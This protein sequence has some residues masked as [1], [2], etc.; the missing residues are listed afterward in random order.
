MVN[1]SG[2]G[3]WS[4]P[5][6]DGICTLNLDV[7]AKSTV[8]GKRRRR[9]FSQ[10]TAALELWPKERKAL[11]KQWLKSTATNR[12]WRDLLR[13]AGN[14]RFAE[15]GALLLALLETGWVEVQ[16]ERKQGQ[17]QTARVEFIALESL[18]ELV[19][20]KNRQQLAQQQRQLNELHFSHPMLEL[21]RQDLNDMPAER[22]L[23][24]YELLSALE[25]W[26]EQQQYGTRRDF[27]QFARGATKSVSSSEWSW[28]SEGLDLD[29]WGVGKHT[30]VLMFGANCQLLFDSGQLDLAAVPDFIALSPETVAAVKSITNPPRH[31]RIV[32]NQ[33][34]FEK[35]S[36]QID[37]DEALLMVPGHPPRW[38]QT[39]V[40]RLFELAPA[41]IAVACD[42]DPAGIWIAQTI[43]R[44]CERCD[45]NWFPWYMG[46]D[47]LLRLKHKLPLSERDRVLLKTLGDSS[48]PES[49]HALIRTMEREGI[50]GEQEELFRNL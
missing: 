50:K 28:L 31:W 32:E 25:S 37:R 48:L 42:P 11:L 20:L 22:A 7:G 43:G 24:R 34:C 39:A 38:W 1:D 47:D 21:L 46:S 9:C 8:R 5:D 26:R 27:S 10:S 13:L 17:W 30:A 6:S 2:Q 16:E 4:E 15:A 33:T 23:K 40:S 12:L 35:L 18:R 49:L 29:E 3:S 14:N 36:R 45:C 19:G 41:N 44:L